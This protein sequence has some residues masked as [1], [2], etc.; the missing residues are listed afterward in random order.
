M[1]N[2]GNPPFRFSSDSDHGVHVAPQFQTPENKVMIDQS[3][4]MDIM[5]DHCQDFSSSQE[6]ME[7]LPQPH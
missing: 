4:D 5:D 2:N 3:P 7:S 6:D 1:A